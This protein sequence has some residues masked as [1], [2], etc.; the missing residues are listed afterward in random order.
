MSGHASGLAAECYGKTIRDDERPLTV[1][2][3]M[4]CQLS[5]GATI[6]HRNCIYT[7][8]QDS[9]ASLRDVD[10]PVETGVLR[11]SLS[12]LILFSGVCTAK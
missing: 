8:R 3:A 4:L 9:A 11:R 2:S 12:E 7:A 1:F 10:I 5:A 6:I